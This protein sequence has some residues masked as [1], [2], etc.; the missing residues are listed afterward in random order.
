MTMFKHVAIVCTFLFTAVWNVNAYEERAVL[1]KTATREQIKEALVM[2][3]QWNPFS[4]QYTDRA[5]WDAFLV[6]N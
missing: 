3:Q 1:E 2:N 4:I 5:A 6:E